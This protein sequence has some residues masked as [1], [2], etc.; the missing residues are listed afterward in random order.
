MHRIL[1]NDDLEIGKWYI[2]QN[3]TAFSNGEMSAP[4]P[5]LV[6]EVTGRKYI[7]NRQWAMD[8]NNQAL[9]NYDIYGPLDLKADV[10]YVRQN[11]AEC[12][13]EAR[14]S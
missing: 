7:G 10:E 9:D 13:A 5:E 3:K 4:R 11:E 2:I 12:L 6:R 1:T 14:Q 8:D